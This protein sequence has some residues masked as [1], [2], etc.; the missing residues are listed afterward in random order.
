[1]FREDETPVKPAKEDRNRLLF[2]IVPEKTDMYANPYSSS[3]A[4]QFSPM[5]RGGD[6]GTAKC[7]RFPQKI[8]QNPHLYLQ[9]ISCG[10]QRISL[11]FV[12]SDASVFM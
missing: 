5:W 6:W 10:N 2:A 4:L 3:E 12:S 11:G 1:M 9:V 8:W 7:K